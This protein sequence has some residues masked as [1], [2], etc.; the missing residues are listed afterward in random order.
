MMKKKSKETSQKT[1]SPALSRPLHTLNRFSASL[2]NSQTPVSQK[3]VNL[4]ATP[5]H[6]K[7]SA[8]EAFSSIGAFDSPCIGTTQLSLDN[9]PCVT[10][11]MGSG[12]LEDE[13]LHFLADENFPSF[14]IE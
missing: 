7:T 2:S 4:S 6:L 10:G 13:T 3:T 11:K 1:T 12:G 5:G 9:S 14:M 8:Q